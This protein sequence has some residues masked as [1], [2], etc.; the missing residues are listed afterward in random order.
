MQVACASTVYAQT[1]AVMLR[2]NHQNPVGFEA[3]AT[4]PV[5]QVA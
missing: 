2:V 1:S 4:A 5:V 3:L